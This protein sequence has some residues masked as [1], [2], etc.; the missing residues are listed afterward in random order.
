[1][2]EFVIHD[3]TNAPTE[4]KSTLEEAKENYN[5]MIP[6]VLGVMAEAPSLLF[7]YW[8]GGRKFLNSS[9][10]RQEISVVLQTSNVENNCE[11]CVPASTMAAIGWEIDEETIT[12]MRDETALPSERLEALRNF[13]LSVVRDRGVVNDEQLKAFLDAGFN[14]Q[15]VLEVVLGVSLKVM[16]N[17]TNHIAKTPLDESW[18]EAAW[19]RQ[20]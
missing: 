20:S 5:G 15:N 18:A 8:E 9:L 17:Y 1:M 13:T 2:V 11:Y 7:T 6:N 14:Q 4:S 10:T 19:H 12:A 3:E 16:S